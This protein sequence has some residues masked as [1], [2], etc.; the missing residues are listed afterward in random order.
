MI[1]TFLLTVIAAVLLW[2]FILR[3]R[4]M[5]WRFR[6]YQRRQAEASGPRQPAAPVPAMT[7]LLCD[8]KGREEH[9]ITIHT[10]DAP[11]TYTY[12]GKTYRQEKRLHRGAD[13][14]WEYRR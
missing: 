5:Q 9:E 7:F 12:A 4:F 14:V 11:E 2:A 13:T 6:A 8:S 3:D 10:A 1:D